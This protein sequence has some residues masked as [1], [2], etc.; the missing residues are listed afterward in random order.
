MKIAVT[1]ATGFIGKYLVETLINEGVSILVLGR[2]IDKLNNVFDDTIEKIETDYSYQQLCSQLNG[3]DIV[4]HLASRLMQRDT[5]SLILNPFIQT[6][7]INTENLYQAALKVGVRQVIHTS[8]ISVYSFQND[9]PFKED[10][11]ARPANIYG[12]SK[13]FAEQNGDYLS[14]KSTLNVVNLRLARLFGVGERDSVVFTKYIN[15]A[16]QGK[17]LEVWGEGKTRIDFI[18][19]K[20]VIAALMSVIYREESISGTFNIGSGHAYTITKI[21]E[22]INLAFN[23]KNN[24]SFNKAKQEVDFI[25]EMD[26]SKAKKTLSWEPEWSLTKAVNDI[27]TILIKENEK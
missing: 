2:C 23:N 10:Q 6:N 19:I 7:I 25:I 17:T 9:L 22:T 27:K 4:V 18:Y 20:D 24:I 8:S 13:L 21:A 15:L 12:V 11:I 3:V 16:K 26:I 14:S 5:D 1:G